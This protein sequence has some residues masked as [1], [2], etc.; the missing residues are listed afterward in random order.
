M[1]TAGFPFVEIFF[2]LVAN[3]AADR[4]IQDD[5]FWAVALQYSCST[6]TITNQEDCRCWWK[7]LAVCMIAAG[8]YWVEENLL[9][10]RLDW[11]SASSV[12]HNGITFDY[13]TRLAYIQAEHHP[14]NWR[15]WTSQTVCFSRIHSYC[16]SVRSGLF[17]NAIWTTRDQEGI[18]GS[19]CILSWGLSAKLQREFETKHSERGL[20]QELHYEPRHYWIEPRLGLYTKNFIPY[21]T[22]INL[23]HV[24]SSGGQAPHTTPKPNLTVANDGS[25]PVGLAT[26][27]HWIQRFLVWSFW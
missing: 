1:A 7:K 22:N 2:S 27:K 11:Y 24:L 16:L 8:Y 14:T 13:S 5:V 18:S 25:T 10:T 26:I 3:Q 12:S 17:C 9:G 6:L 4:C 20:V 23:N 19:W 21:L 15:N